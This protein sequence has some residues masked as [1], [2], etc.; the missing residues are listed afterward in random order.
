MSEVVSAYNT[1]LKPC[2]QCKQKRYLQEK[3]VC[4]TCRKWN[5]KGE[6][7]Y[8]RWWQRRMRDA[9]QIIYGRRFYDTNA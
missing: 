9:K 3:A 6:G 7:D 1:T 4:N 2:P 5:S 8:L